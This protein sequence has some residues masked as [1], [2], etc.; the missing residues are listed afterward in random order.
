MKQF[1]NI[2]KQLFV[3]LRTFKIDVLLI[4]YSQK[5]MRVT[6]CQW[7]LLFVYSFY[8]CIINGVLLKSQKNTEI[9]SLWW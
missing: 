1:K 9:I 7:Q 4:S 5:N 3:T 8:L 2:Y 6:T